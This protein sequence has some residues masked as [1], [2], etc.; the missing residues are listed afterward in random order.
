MRSRS[1]SRFEK[2]GV[3]VTISSTAGLVAGVLFVGLAICNVVFMLEAER[4]QN[5]AAKRR[6]ALLHRM[7]GYAYVMLFCSM[8]YVMSPRAMGLGLSDKLP[9]YLFAHIVLFLVLVPLLVLKILIVRRYKHRHSLLMPLGL[10][11]FI[12]SVLLVAI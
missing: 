11:I 10:S 6:L 5:P 12:I 2:K 8:A 7:G 1:G 9:R 4:T 3:L